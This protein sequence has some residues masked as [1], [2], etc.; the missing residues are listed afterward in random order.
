MFPRT[1]TRNRACI[2]QDGDGIA[3]REIGLAD[4]C[5]GYLMDSEIDG[6]LRGN[7]DI[8]PMESLNHWCRP[9]SGGDDREYQSSRIGHPGTA[10]D[11]LCFQSFSLQSVRRDESAT[12]TPLH[13]SPHQT[14][15]AA[16]RERMKRRKMAGK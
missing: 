2:R 1:I 10:H 15:R 11:R 14:G 6:F 9:E 13:H 4:N 7:E 5:I 3:A 16:G 12:L 8:V